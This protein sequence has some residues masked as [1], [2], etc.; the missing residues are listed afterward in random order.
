VLTVV[1]KLC[2]LSVPSVA[3]VRSVLFSR[4]GDNLQEMFARCSYGKLQYTGDVYQ[5]EFC[6]VDL[7]TSCNYQAWAY[8]ANSLL[9]AALNVRS[10]CGRCWFAGW[11]MLRCE[12][13]RGSRIQVTL[14]AAPAGEH[15]G[16]QQHC[17]HIPQGRGQPDRGPNM[18]PRPGLC[19]LQVCAPWLSFQTAAAQILR[20]CLG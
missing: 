3:D 14:P 20:L 19:Q 12:L 1:L 11:C 15:L 7:A 16:L 5:V 10:W 4:P 6:P 9:Q 8:T 2:G 13:L 17:L 18:W